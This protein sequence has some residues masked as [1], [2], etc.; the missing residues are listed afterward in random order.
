MLSA[1]CKQLNILYPEDLFPLFV[2][3]VFGATRVFGTGTWKRTTHSF[4]VQRE[5]CC[6]GEWW[7]GP[8]HSSLPFPPWL[9]QAYSSWTSPTESKTQNW[10]VCSKKSAGAASVETSEDSCINI[11]WFELMIL[12]RE[13]QLEAEAFL[14]IFHI[15]LPSKDTE[16]CFAVC[17]S[18]G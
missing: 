2:L 15:I 17:S 9:L 8:L 3:Y 18:K 1:L 5:R 12:S 16:A 6:W 7:H 4:S 11:N 14:K 10:R 13:N